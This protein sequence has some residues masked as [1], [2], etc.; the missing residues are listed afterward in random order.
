MKIKYFRL[1]ALNRV[2]NREK[3]CL[4]FCENYK[5]SDNE[6]V[7]TNVMHTNVLNHIRPF[8]YTNHLTS[9]TLKPFF[10]YGTT[11]IYGGG[12]GGG[13][14]VASVASGRCRSRG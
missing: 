1:A 12:L 14:G 6:S 5:N 8:L 3:T 4:K 10:S 7:L 2:L 9:A 11:C 13:G